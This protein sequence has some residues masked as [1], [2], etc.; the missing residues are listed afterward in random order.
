MEDAPA[1][2][3]PLDE[4]PSAISRLI[5]TTVSQYTGRGPR[6][7]HTYVTGDIVAVVMKDSLTTAERTLAADGRDELVIQVRR[8]FQQRM[9]SDFV[10]GVQAITGRTVIGFFSDHQ[11]DPDIA[12]ETFVLEPQL[13]QQAGSCSS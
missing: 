5:E 12:V 8:T 10:P 9:R 2:P 4:Q 11:I 7:V 3:L 6:S 13:L 1:R